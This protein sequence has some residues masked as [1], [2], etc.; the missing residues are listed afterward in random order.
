MI[1]LGGVRALDERVDEYAMVTLW[2]LLILI[3]FA[4]PIGGALA[5]AKLAMVGVGGYALAVTVGLA[6]GACC[7]WAMWTTHKIVVT[8]LQRH[9]DWEH[10]MS[11]WYFRAFYFAK[12]LWI[13]V[14]LFLGA[15]LSSLLLRLVF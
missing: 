3:C 14:A 5:S 8:N 4:I 11:E 9:P 10:S 1:H 7:A 15:W 2:Q 13:A 12:M 6:V